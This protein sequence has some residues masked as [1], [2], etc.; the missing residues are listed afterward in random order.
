LLV[1]RILSIAVTLTI[2]GCLWLL[3]RLVLGFAA[4]AFYARRDVMVD[5]LARATEAG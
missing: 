4:R 2:A 1:G 3:W 5:R